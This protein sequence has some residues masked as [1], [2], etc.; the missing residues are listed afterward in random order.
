MR[1]VRGVLGVGLV[2][3]A[4]IG[5]AA[6]VTLGWQNRLPERLPNSGGVGDRPVLTTIGVD[7]VVAVLGEAAIAVWLLGLVAFALSRGLSGVGRH[8]VRTGVQV[9]VCGFVAAAASA[10]LMLLAPALDA[11]SATDVRLSWGYFVA[12]LVVPMLVAAVLGLVAYAL[13]GKPPTDRPAGATP[14]ERLLWWESRALRPVLWLS[15]ALALSG[16]V[17]VAALVPLIGVAGWAGA[18]PA[19]TALVL[20]PFARYRLVIDQDAVRCAVGPYRRRVPMS[21][22]LA[23]E[24]GYLP[25]GTW[26][27]RSALHGAAA[28]LPLLPGPALAL[29]L[30]DGTRRLVTCRDV[31][32]AVETVNTLR[33]RRTTAQS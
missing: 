5:G 4:M 18:A 22:I 14:D 29:R 12:C 32:T 27:T 17:L 11:P 31:R 26:L 1:A 6:V 20:L 24:E 3:A 28:D 21:R 13:A 30:T 33:L 10:L 23:A 19:A 9:G 16:V 8:W 7:T 25:V 15:G 2:P